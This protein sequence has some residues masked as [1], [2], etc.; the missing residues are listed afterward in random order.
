MSNNA[1]KPVG[2]VY[3]NPHHRPFE[4]ASIQQNSGIEEGFN[5]IDNK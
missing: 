3:P 5:R 2:E 4:F 1:V